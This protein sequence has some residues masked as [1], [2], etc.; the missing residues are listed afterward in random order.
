MRVVDPTSAAP[1]PGSTPAR[2]RRPCSTPCRGGV[3]PL[4]GT[5]PAAVELESTAT[6]LDSV[7]EQLDLMVVDLDLAMVGLASARARGCRGDKAV[8]SLVRRLLLSF[9]YAL[10]PFPPAA[11]QGSLGAAQG[12]C[13]LWSSG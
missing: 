10:T 2:V 3:G 6:E 12:A 8:D 13:R 7:A 11:D 9:P 1:L 4:R 5:D